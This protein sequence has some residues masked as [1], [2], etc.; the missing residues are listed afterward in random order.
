MFMRIERVQDDEPAVVNPAIGIGETDFIS[1]A[2]RRPERI[3]L[4][5]NGMRRLKTFT[6]RKMIV[7]KKAQAN[8]PGGTHA[9]F[10]RQNEF[11]RPDD[12]RRAGEKKLPLFERLMHETKFVEF[13]IAQA[14]MNEL[15]RGRR[16]AARKI[17]LLDKPNGESASGGVPRDGGAIHAAPDDEK[18]KHNARRFLRL[19]GHYRTNFGRQL[20]GR[21]A[22]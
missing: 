15:G 16:C 10:V 9:L 7:K 2:Q 3:A 14:A 6:L 8:E 22:P 11:E 1:L 12:V 19:G 4:Q 21:S 5:C 17:V 18:I 20:I 13:E